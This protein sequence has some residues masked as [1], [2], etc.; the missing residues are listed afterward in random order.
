MGRSWNKETMNKSDFP[1]IIYQ[2]NDGLTKLNVTFDED[3]VW[4]TQEQMAELFQNAKLTIN[5]HIKNVFED[6]EFR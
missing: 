1:I 3:T 2:T 4:L 6:G 5:E